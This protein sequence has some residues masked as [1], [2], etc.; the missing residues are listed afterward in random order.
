MQSE[1]ET[2]ISQEYQSFESDFFDHI[3]YEAE[4]MAEEI[5]AVIP[6]QFDRS[7]AEALTKFRDKLFETY[8]NKDLKTETIFN[9][10]T[11]LHESRSFLFLNKLIYNTFDQV[12]NP[13]SA[14]QNIL[15]YLTLFGA[16]SAFQIASYFTKQKSGEPDEDYSARI[17]NYA[18][19]IRR[20]TNILVDLDIIN[21]IRVVEA[22]PRPVAIYA[23]KFAHQEDIDKKVNWYKEKKRSKNEVIDEKAD[24]E[25][26]SKIKSSEGLQKHWQNK[27]TTLDDQEK[28]TIIET[29]A[30][31]KVLDKKATIKAKEELLKDGTKDRENQLKVIDKT[32]KVEVDKAASQI[33]FV[34][35]ELREDQKVCHFIIKVASKG[36]REGWEEPCGQEHIN[37]KCVHCN[38]YICPK[39][40]EQHLQR[41]HKILITGKNPLEDHYKL[42][43]M[44]NAHPLLEKMKDDMQLPFEE[45]KQLESGE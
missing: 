21:S 2:K 33:Q 4:R 31:K 1:A 6:P 42:S 9:P 3:K 12:L 17:Q 44:I 38:Q 24:I 25:L 28:N 34:K 27:T 11:T 7:I 45:K 36:A 41:E 39:H 14:M 13:D 40:I 26:Q 5:P 19:T 35:H 15:T 23:A 30:T 22:F 18:K 37:Q 16:G 8:I 29:K 10:I 32:E 43:S 20:N